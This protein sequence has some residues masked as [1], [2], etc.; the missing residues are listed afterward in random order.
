MLRREFLLALS[1]MAMKS[2]VSGLT[3]GRI[4]IGAPSAHGFASPVNEGIIAHYQMGTA[5]GTM[6][7]DASGQGN[8]GT[9][10]NSPIILPAG[11]TFNG[12]NQYAT[13]PAAISAFKTVVVI[14]EFSLPALYGAQRTVIGSDTA[15]K[16]NVTLNCVADA[17]TAHTLPTIYTTAA[18]TGSS[19]ALPQVAMLT[20]VADATTDHFYIND[21]EVGSYAATQTGNLANI[22]GT[23]Q[24]GGSTNLGQF[25][26]G[27]I[28]DVRFYSQELNAA[29]VL[30]NYNAALVDP[31]LGPL[32]IPSAN[33]GTTSVCVGEGD[34]ITVGY[35]AAAPYF[36]LA[37]ITTNPTRWNLGVDGYTVGRALYDGA[38]Y[39]QLYA[40]L[41]PKNIWS[42]LL[43]INDL[44][45]GWTPAQVF[46]MLVTK[47]QAVRAVGF[48][49][50]TCT[51][52][53][54]IGQDANRDT[55]NTLIRA[56]WPSFATALC[57]FAADPFI[58]PDGSYA[59]TTYFNTDGIHPNTLGQQRMGLVY[60]PVASS[61]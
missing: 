17:V 24:I 55:V 25:F 60:G 13:L 50:I 34:S 54:C 49:N 12:S 37:T 56:N 35:H 4:R 26:L 46:S 47:H 43:G 30:A 32:L 11:V 21:H 1:T 28:F 19:E 2:K 33:L 6:L 20:F 42:G 29:Q 51:L 41:A 18:S 7:P 23:I 58:G 38:D 5:S 14:G 44:L 59:N 39:A 8:T 9:L 3:R 22:G 40:P 27:T 48:K 61:I 53:S 36:S 45:Q 52:P 15:G 31:I 57:D 10:V 16:T